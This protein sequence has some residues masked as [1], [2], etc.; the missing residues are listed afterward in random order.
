MTESLDNSISKTIKD[1][2][3]MISEYSIPELNELTFALSRFGVAASFSQYI[4]ELE[5]EIDSSV[6]AQS[7]DYY[8]AVRANQI[9]KYEH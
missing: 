5:N 6:V 1:Q 4:P 7:S 8:N 3:E 9:D 2:A